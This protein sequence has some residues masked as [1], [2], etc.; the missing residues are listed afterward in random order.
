L[1]ILHYLCGAILKTKFKNLKKMKVNGYLIEKAK[2]SWHDRTSERVKRG[3]AYLVY[4]KNGKN[5]EMFRT[6]KEAKSFANS[7]P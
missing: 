5:F 1:I 7:K 2:I 4:A 6:L 3:N